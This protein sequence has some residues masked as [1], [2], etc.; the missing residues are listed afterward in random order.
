MCIAVSLLMR[1]KAN[2]VDRCGPERT[3]NQTVNRKDETS[4]LDSDQHPSLR[5]PSQFGSVSGLA[6]SGFGHEEKPGDFR[7]HLRCDAIEPGG[8]NLKEIERS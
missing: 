4:K 7:A 8:L 5:E 2:S 1:L 3:G 6:L